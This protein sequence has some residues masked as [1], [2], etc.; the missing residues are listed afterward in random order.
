MTPAD[1]DLPPTGVA[2]SDLERQAAKRLADAL[3]ER[4]RAVSV[5]TVSVRI[6]EGACVAL[7]ALIA[8]GGGLIGLKWPLVGAAIVLLAA[9]SFYAE[10]SLG[11]P[12]IGRLVPTRA[13]QNVMS[14][15]PGPAWQQDVE[16][17]LTAGYDLP[18]SYPSGEWL[19]RRFSGR[20]TTD[21]L[22]LW[23]GIV[24]VFVALMLQAADVDEVW[25]QTIQLIGSVV[26]LS[27]TAAQADRALAGD[28]EAGEADLRATDNLLAVLDEALDESDGDPPIAVCF[29]GAEASSA[30]G[31]A[32]F[33]RIFEAD[34][35]AEDAAVINFVNGSAPG[36]RGAARVLITT[37]EGDLASLKMNDEMGSESP[38]KPEPAI[39]RTTTAATIAR[40]RGLR[41]TTVVGSG[42]DAVDVGLD[43]ID[44]SAPA[45]E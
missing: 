29:F 28:A 44:N 26:L 21:R 35:R 15:P 45:T 42:D 39:L 7:H 34:L 22:L 4:G 10:R 27:F 40:R 24:P 8:L 9:S 19:T 2:G 1:T 33:F 30:Q 31:A 18:A 41:A 13:S 43:L 12:L 16:I 11:L 23:S 32:A 14:P 3:R 5:E 6:S 20:L 25:V 17:V 37:K 38:I 36:P